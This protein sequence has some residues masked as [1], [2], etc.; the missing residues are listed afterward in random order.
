MRLEMDILEMNGDIEIGII[1]L[2]GETK[3]VY[4]DLLDEGAFE[5][6]KRGSV[7]ITKT[8]DGGKEKIN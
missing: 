7:N 1:N 5:G 3:Y 8:F 2:Q 4:W 6:L